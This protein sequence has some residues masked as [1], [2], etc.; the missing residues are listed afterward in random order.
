MASEFYNS[1]KLVLGLY[2]AGDEFQIAAEYSG[3]SY[4]GYYHL[5]NGF[6]YTDPSPIIE[7]QPLYPYV[8]EDKREERKYNII[9]DTE[10]GNHPAPRF[11][12][13]KPTS[14]DISQGWMLRYFV[15]RV[16]DRT[17]TE[18]DNTQYESYGSDD[19]IDGNLHKKISIRWKITGTTLA[20]EFTN[21]GKLRTAEYIMPGISDYLNNLLEFSEFSPTWANQY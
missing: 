19:G 17:I 4:V 20:I 9:K 10:T 3:E 1:E 13:P 16:P 7:R 5:D 21:S 6:I 15:Q 18:I 12:L 2:T 8:L 11:H 14:A